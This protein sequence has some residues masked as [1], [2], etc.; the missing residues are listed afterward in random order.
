M[1]I[2]KGTDNAVQKDPDE[3][4]GVPLP[5]PSPILVNRMVYENVPSTGYTGIPLEMTGEMGLQYKDANGD[6]RR[7][8][9]P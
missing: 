1:M 8:V 7:Y 5:S 3:D 6:V 9:T 4:D 2:S